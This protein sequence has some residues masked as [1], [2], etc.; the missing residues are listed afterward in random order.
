MD[1]IL[2]YIKTNLYLLMLYICIISGDSDSACDVCGQLFSTEVYMMKHRKHKHPLADIGNNGRRGLYKCQLCLFS[3]DDVDSMQRH[4]SLHRHSQRRQLQDT[5]HPIVIDSHNGRQSCST[6]AS[7]LKWVEKRPT[8]N[9]KHI[10]GERP[11]KCDICEAQFTNNIDLERH[12]RTHTGEKP[13][14]CDICGAQFSQSANLKRHLRIHTGEKPFKCD[15]C[16]AQF[17]LKGNLE[18]HM[19]THTGEKPFKCDICGARFTDSGDLKNHLR[20]H[21]GE[22]PYKCDICGAQFNRN[23]HLKAH[24][25]IHTREKP[26]KCDICRAQF[27]QS[28]CLKKHLT[29]HT[30]VKPYKCD[31][32]GAQFTNK[33]TLKT[34]QGNVHQREA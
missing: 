4:L 1:W 5:D 22:K 33:L 24:L 29:I 14:K 13:F 28:G 18:R 23:G 19:R 17:T 15:I 31:I 8:K 21:T 6:D 34:H 27:A 2:R 25:R 20:T 26:F 7:N 10:Q 16:G 11:F 3:D 9:Y 30:G 12:L 32:C